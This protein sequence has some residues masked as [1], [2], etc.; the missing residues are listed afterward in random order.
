MM[1]NHYPNF[2]IEKSF[3]IMELMKARQT[4]NKLENVSQSYCEVCKK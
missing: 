3:T 2:E 1:M 4:E